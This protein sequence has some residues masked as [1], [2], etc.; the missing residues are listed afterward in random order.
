MI[1]IKEQTSEVESN[2][3]K[4]DEFQKDLIRELASKLENIKSDDS[5]DMRELVEERDEWRLR[6]A[7]LA[8]QVAKGRTPEWIKR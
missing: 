6:Y 2:S 7:R 8:K 5:M 4:E 1:E 3:L